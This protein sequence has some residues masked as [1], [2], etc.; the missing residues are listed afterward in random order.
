MES[1]VESVL[2]DFNFDDFDVFELEK[3]FDNV[4]SVLLI[5]GDFLL[6]FNIILMCLVFVFIFGVFEEV[7]F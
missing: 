2:D 4:L 7:L 3:R 1:V 5:L 6:V